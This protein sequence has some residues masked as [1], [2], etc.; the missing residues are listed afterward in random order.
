LKATWFIQIVPTE[1]NSDTLARIL[2]VQNVREAMEVFGP[3]SLN[4][5][6]AKTRFATMIGEDF[7]KFF[8]DDAAVKEMLRQ[9][10]AQNPQGQPVPGQQRPMQ[11]KPVPGAM[12]NGLTPREPR[13]QATVAA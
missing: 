12:A 2:F 4:M 3:E 6:H 7:A 10:Q 11:R 9:M 5:D 13:V 8:N 1:K